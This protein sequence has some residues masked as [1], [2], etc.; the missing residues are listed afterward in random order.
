MAAVKPC[1]YQ[2]VVTVNDVMLV[3]AEKMWHHIVCVVGTDISIKLRGE[4]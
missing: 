1:A 3:E 4:V 2:M